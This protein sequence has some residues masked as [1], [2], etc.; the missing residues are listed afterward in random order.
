LNLHRNRGRWQGDF[1][2]SSSIKSIFLPVSLL[3]IDGCS[4][5]GSAIQKIYVAGACLFVSDNALIVIKGI[6]LILHVGYVEK[7]ILSWERAII[8]KY[9]SAIKQRWKPLHSNWNRD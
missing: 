6:T 5:T 9:L 4:F 3:I 2:K 7:M 1:L 8:E